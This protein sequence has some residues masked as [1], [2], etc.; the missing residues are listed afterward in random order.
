MTTH[1]FEEVPDVN[2]A[3][4]RE[5]PLSKVTN[6]ALEY[7]R[8]VKL[9]ANDKAGYAGANDYDFFGITVARADLGDAVA[10]YLRSHP[11]LVPVYVTG[12][13]T[14]GDWLYAAASG[15]F[16]TTPNGPGLAQAR[17]TRSTAGIVSAQVM[18]YNPDQAMEALRENKVTF[19][20][21]FLTGCV[22]P[23]GKFAETADKGD[24]LLT[25]VDGG[26]DSGEVCKV[27]DDGPGGLLEIT[28]NDASADSCELQL[29]GEAFKLAVGKQLNFRTRLAI[30]D[31]SETDMF[32]GLAIADTTV[33]A[34][35]TDRVGFQVDNDGNLDCLIEQ[36]G[37]EYNVDSGVDIAD[38]AAIGSFADYDVE[39]AFFWDGVDTI[40]FSINGVVVKEFTDNG[41]TILIPDDEAMTPTICVKAASAA[42]QTVWVDEIQVE[43][44]R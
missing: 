3:P 21:D 9:D 36:D 13:V 11:A 26:T 7:G 35:V 17:Q 33:M 16:Q 12:A 18:G 28:T 40:Q 6:T 27:A 22:E 8:R 2:E 1:D 41:T 20:D 44:Q 10:I 32:V 42:A 34:G 14:R 25:V 37:T 15:G 4:L 19:Y 5:S 29:N 23:G 38:C 39:L 31:V 43:M 24:W 30:K